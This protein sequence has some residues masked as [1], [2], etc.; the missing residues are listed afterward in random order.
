[1]KKAISY[2]LIFLGLQLLVSTPVNIAIKVL[3][4]RHIV[5]SPYLIL[6]PMILTSVVSIAV[7]VKAGWA[8]VSR[9]YLLTRPWS[10]LFWSALAALGIVIP[11]VA[12]QELLPEL[13]N[14][15]EQE[16]SRIMNTRGGY[17]V[18]CLLAPVT[19]ELVFRGA[20]LRTLL[21][22]RS[23]LVAIAISAL[24]FAAVHMNPAQMPHAFLS[25]LLLGW[26]YW[27]TGSIIPGVVLHWVNNTVSYVLIKLYPDPDMRLID[28]FGTNRHVGAA[29]IFSLFILL[30][31]IYQ[32]SLLMKRADQ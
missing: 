22:S 16:L 29:V 15:V 27:R 6:V 23:P 20:V 18:V 9:N 19:E 3:E 32:L 2:T 25:G 4:M 13:P 7:F 1:M 30:P 12:L 14:I 8:P 26:M 28:L 5:N 17:F 24:F 21:G 11:S 10:V 31:A